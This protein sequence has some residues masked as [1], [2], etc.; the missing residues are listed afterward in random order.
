MAS[1]SDTSDTTDIGD[2]LPT[3]TGRRTAAVLWDALRG[4]RFVLVLAAVFAGVAAA[5]ELIAPA[6]LGR[7]VD[8]I[9]NDSAS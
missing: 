1:A 5:L 2:R 6:T 3:A 4:R 8:D 7:V 9:T